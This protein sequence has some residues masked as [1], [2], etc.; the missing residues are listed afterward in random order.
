MSRG[1]NKVILVGNLGR[2]PEIKY[3]DGGGSVCNVTLATSEKWKDKGGEEHE[4]TEWHKLVFWGRLAEVVAEFC[5]KGQ[6]IYVEGKLKT[7]KWEDSDGNDRYTVK[8]HCFGMQ[9]LGGGNRDRDSGGQQGAS[10]RDK[11][12]PQQQAQQQNAFEDDDIPF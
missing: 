6:Q 12:K 8:V 9:M 2:D 11:P 3:F 1:V 5:T 4:E 7:E 10:F